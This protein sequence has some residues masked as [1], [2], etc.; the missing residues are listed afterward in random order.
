MLFAYA[1][2][3]SI[4]SL[5]NSLIGNFW[6]QKDPLYLLM[7]HLQKGGAFADGC[8]DELIDALRE[9]GKRSRGILRVY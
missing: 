6:P 5:L 9:I 2:L 8:V 4:H 3:K 7:L 1:A